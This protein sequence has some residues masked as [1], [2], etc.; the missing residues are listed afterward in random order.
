MK[1]LL[2]ME[3]YSMHMEGNKKFSSLWALKEQARESTSCQPYSEFQQLHET[4]KL[5][6]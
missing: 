5:A 6:K 1:D 2:I 3:Y 4:A